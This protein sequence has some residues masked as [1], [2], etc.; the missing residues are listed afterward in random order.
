MQVEE[1]KEVEIDLSSMVCR[2]R[3]C[4]ELNIAFFISI[5]DVCCGAEGW[6][7]LAELI[8][9]VRFVEASSDLVH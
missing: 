3:L 7:D 4:T 2:V 9:L 1:V 6:E 5:E 8:V